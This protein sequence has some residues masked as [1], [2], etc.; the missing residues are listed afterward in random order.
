MYKKEITY[1]D[2]N[3]NDV[4]ELVEFECT[5]RKMIDYDFK[6]LQKKVGKLQKLVEKGK[7]NRAIL[8]EY[9]RFFDEIVNVGYGHSKDVELPN[10]EK[11]TRFIPA[12]KEEIEG[13]TQSDGYVHMVLDF[14][15]DPDSL[16][17]L[18]D[19][20]FD[21]EHRDEVLDWLKNK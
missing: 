15:K 16:G 17:D 14:A 2:A 4:N 7:D 20:A 6:A 21:A 1:K 13:F 10:G 12:S 19:K 8:S 18:V 3:R 5:G 11:I 9:F